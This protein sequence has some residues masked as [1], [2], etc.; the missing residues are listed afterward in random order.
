MKHNSWV[1]FVLSQLSLG[2]LQL[3]TDYFGRTWLIDRTLKS[4]TFYLFVFN[5]IIWESSTSEISKPNFV[6]FWQKIRSGKNCLLWWQGE[7]DKQLENWIMKSLFKFHFLVVIKEEGWGVGRTKKFSKLI[8]LLFKG[9]LLK[10]N[11]LNDRKGIF[12][13]FFPLHERFFKS[14]IS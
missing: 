2:T 11:I 14:R 1:N 5:L 3:L 7:K 8:L 13:G 6:G 9:L 10:A 4:Y 12:L